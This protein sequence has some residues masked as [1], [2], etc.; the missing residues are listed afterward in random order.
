MKFGRKMMVESVFPPSAQRLFFSH[1]MA[2]THSLSHFIVK[3]IFLL[4]FFFEPFNRTKW[5]NGK[6]WKYK[7]T[8]TT[9]IMIET[10]FY[11]FHSVRWSRLLRM[12]FFALL[13][14]EEFFLFFSHAIQLNVSPGRLACRIGSV[15]HEPR[16]L[17]SLLHSIAAINDDNMG[18]VACKNG[19]T[20]TANRF[21]LS[22]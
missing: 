21:S 17:E 1:S 22:R 11:G 5:Q 8:V 6:K 15:C 12:D 16:Q 14:T 19:T 4:P 9:T 2:A 20:F 18:G 7:K 13:N 10:L 3:W